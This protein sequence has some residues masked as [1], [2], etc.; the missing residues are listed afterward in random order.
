VF[1]IRVDDVL[2]C[3]RVPEGRAQSVSRPSGR[4]SPA[5]GDEPAVLI[6]KPMEL[7]E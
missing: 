5:A 6:W 3:T 2:D 4:V 7:E 1:G